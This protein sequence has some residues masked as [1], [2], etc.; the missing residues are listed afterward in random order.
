MSPPG[1]ENAQPLLELFEPSYCN[2]ELSNGDALV[3]VPERLLHVLPREGR[4]LSTR[5]EQTD[6]TC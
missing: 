1:V 5:S 6:A 3:K 2:P 4:A